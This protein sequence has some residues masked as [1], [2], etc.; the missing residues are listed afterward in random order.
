LLR[1]VSAVF[2]SALAVR[3]AQVVTT[4]VDLF[5]GN[6]NAWYSAFAA[7]VADGHWGRLPSVTGSRLFST[8]FPPGYPFV[9]GIGQRALFW[10]DPITAQRWVSA[11]LGAIAA[12]LVAL[13]AWRV[14]TRAP[15][16]VRVAVALLAGGVFALNP[17]TAGAA[18]GLMSEGLYQLVVVGVLLAVNV[19]YS[20]STVR[21]RDLVTLALLVA[22]ATFIRSEGLIL[23]SIVVVVSI[24]ARHGARWS[25]LAVPALAVA[26]VALWVVPLSLAAARPVLV[27]TNA[28]SLVAGANCS[29]TSR[30]ALRGFWS[31]K[32]LV[33]RRDAVPRETRQRLDM[34]ARATR[35]NPFVLAP[36]IGV[37]SEADIS[38]ALMK[39]GVRAIRAEKVRFVTVMPARVARGLGVYWTAPQTR[40]ELFEG[41]D[42]R[43]QTA[44]RVFH[45][46]VVLPFSLV[47]LV[48]AA[49][50]R[51]RLA[52]SLRS[53]AEPLQ[54]LPSAVLVAVTFV[55][56]ALTY[57]SA[58][59]RAAAEPA[60]AIGA[61]IGMVTAW[62]SARASIRP[63]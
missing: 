20:Q 58:R 55:F 61:G 9:V 31:T 3:G 18:T 28:G 48:A 59:M 7:S 56:I 63:R 1:V 50:R 43:W 8:Q 46:V 25:V 10:V 54:L 2:A 34:S 17:M 26:I 52:A 24:A 16:R 32:C 13:V 19:A 60:L 12:A 6:D 27:S 42:R 23:L 47:T 4:E 36:R 30:G 41:R 38:A 15:A 53:T 21:R 44:G 49:R 11:F 14:A 5:F 51:G 29:L 62:Q 35:A 40:Q 22:A 57:G 37:E 39:R 33:L 45:L